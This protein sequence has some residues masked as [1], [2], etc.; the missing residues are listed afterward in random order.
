ME[1]EG[2]RRA[3]V[4]GFTINSIIGDAHALPFPDGCFDIVTLQFASRHL[5]IMNVASEVL[6][7]LKPG[8]KFHHSDILRPT[9][10]LIEA[11]YGTYLKACVSVTALAFKSGPEAQS[12]RDYFVRAVKMFY[13]P[14]EFSLMLR[15]VGFTD[16]SYRSAISGGLA[17]HRAVRP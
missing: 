4:A 11:I 3:G 14:D 16:V 17:R 8:G 1:A 15:K 2:R 13:S 10:K 6:R 12:C 5:K 9:S 7:V